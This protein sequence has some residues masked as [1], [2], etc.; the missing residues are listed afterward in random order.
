MNILS[1]VY[2]PKRR[3]EWTLGVQ[4]SR[5]FVQ[6]FLKDTSGLLEDLRRSKRPPE[7]TVYGLKLGHNYQRNNKKQK[8]QNGQNKMSNCKQHAAT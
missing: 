7:Q 4:D 8:L 2:G 6:D 3:E 5:S 1:M